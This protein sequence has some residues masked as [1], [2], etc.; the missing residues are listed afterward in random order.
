MNTLKSCT[1]A[2]ALWLSLA[3]CK[4]E[5]TLHHPNSPTIER[6]DEWAPTGLA[7][8]GKLSEV[9]SQ[10]AS[11]LPQTSPIIHAQA[12]LSPYR[13]Y[14]PFHISEELKKILKTAWY[15]AWHNEEVSPY[16]PTN[17]QS[18]LDQVAT[19][20]STHL[21][22]L[23]K[24]RFDWLTPDQQQQISQKI[25]DFVE[26][27]TRLGNETDIQKKLQTIKNL[28]THYGWLA[29]ILWGIRNNKG[30]F[31][32][33]LK[34]LFAESI[35]KI[36]S[37]INAHWIWADEIK[38]LRELAY[39]EEELGEP[40]EPKISTWPTSPRSVLSTAWND[41]WVSI[42]AERTKVKST[43]STVQKVKRN[44]RKIVI[45]AW[46][47][48]HIAKRKIKKNRTIVSSPLSPNFHPFH[49]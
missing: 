19:D 45:R 15:W 33:P 35:G 49:N 44:I 48:L 42:V 43:A 12:S 2:I 1:Y 46:K 30:N 41:R 6:N 28:H 26:D 37:Q 14:I 9:V 22:L 47:K 29:Y 38:K 31:V 23:E 34:W 36:E 3:A 18:F 21:P 10:V 8:A 39:F 7:F 16:T 13:S 27:I 17:V 5:K 32:F 11:L 25:K 4:G 40:K 20:L 24:V